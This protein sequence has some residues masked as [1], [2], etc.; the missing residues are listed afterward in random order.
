MRFSLLIE[1]LGIIYSFSLPHPSPL[2]GEKVGTP[3]TPLRDSRP[4]EPCFLR[5]KREILTLHILFRDIGPYEPCFMVV[6]NSERE[7]GVWFRIAWRQER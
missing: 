5:V 3:H 7:F 6:Y 2:K 4:Y 1:W